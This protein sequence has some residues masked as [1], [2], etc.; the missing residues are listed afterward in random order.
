MMA[1][2][3]SPHLEN[4]CGK[5]LGTRNSYRASL[6]CH[7]G[8]LPINL[9]SADKLVPK[10]WGNLGVR[11]STLFSQRQHHLCQVGHGWKA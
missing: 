3:L 9:I 11:K 8:G 5:G 7:L 1:Q 4:L 6:L 10:D 2:V